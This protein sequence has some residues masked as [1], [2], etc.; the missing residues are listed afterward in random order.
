[1][2]KAQ[3]VELVQKHGEYVFQGAY[4]YNVNLEDGFEL[5]GRVTHY[6]DDEAFKKS[7]FY[8]SGNSYNF[9]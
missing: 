4:V 8:F 3:F 1:M 5:R 2:N 6:D 7:G 9:V